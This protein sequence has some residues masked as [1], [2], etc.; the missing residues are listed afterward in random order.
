VTLSFKTAAV[1]DARGNLM[2]TTGIASDITGQ[3]EVEAARRLS[4]ARFRNLF[5]RN[6]A[7]VYRTTLGGRVLDCNDSFAR[8]LGFSSR[9][10]VRGRNCADFYPDPADR[11]RFLARL[12]E[13]GA[14]TNS[15][16]EL[17]RRDGAAVWVLENVSLLEEGTPAETVVEGTMIDV[18]ER[19]RAL[20]A[21]RE[22][23]EYFRSLIDN[24]LDVIMIVNPNGTIRY[25]SP[26]VE[27][28]LG[29]RPPELT[30]EAVFDYVH[31]EDGEA[32]RRM[33]AAMVHGS[34]SASGEFR[35]RHR[36]GTWRHMEAIGSD[37]SNQP[38]VAGLLVQLRDVTERKV[39][40]E[41][42]A[43]LQFAIQ[44]AAKEWQ[45]TFDAI[46]SPVLVLDGNARIRRL[47]RAA[48]VLSGKT[49]RETIGLAIEAL[50]PGEPWQ[51]SAELA[52]AI[53]SGGAAT[54]GQARDLSTGRSW[55]VAASLLKAASSE[56]ERIILVAREITGVVQLQEKLHHTRTMSA[57]GSLVAGVAHEVRN[58]LFGISA[59]LDAFEA[60][61]GQRE[62]YRQYVAVLRGEL[63]RLSQLMGDLLEFGKPTSLEFADGAI[64]EVVAEAVAGCRALADQAG[65]VLRGA[66]DG[67]FPPI[68]MDRRRLTQVFQNLL[69]NAVRHAPPR[70]AVI[71]E[72][73]LMRGE[74]GRWIDCRVRDAG[75]G[76]RPED[77]PR[78]FE[79]FFTRRRGGTGLG[80]SIV[81]RIVED[82]G[83]RISAG[84][85]PEGGAVVTVRLPVASTGAGPRG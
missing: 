33:F 28:L 63:E 54:S 55:D 71:V 66:L 30:D 45:R 38:S 3:R 78:I 76:F 59:T 70:S 18:T 1:R 72:A 83:G 29:Y 5:E 41:N 73:E 84:N 60:R 6:L 50:G 21:L 48:K 24:A 43:R 82:H 69:D 22:S 65:V 39:A 68:R 77:L 13:R 74:G 17:R 57:M 4:E 61:F 26:S 31:A 7:G 36:D 9:D 44:D 19:R 15:E 37:L 46:E 42:Q 49:Y 20:D 62:E 64:G 81:Q 80:L 67:G 25:G 79:P 47:N 27:R 85:L 12:R 10:E 2:G 52:Q 14:L 58:P 34:G 35:V 11:E 56:S 40:D 51:K 8:I 16:I 75:P 32:V 53:R 23:E